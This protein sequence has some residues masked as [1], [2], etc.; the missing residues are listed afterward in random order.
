GSYEYKTLQSK[1]MESGKICNE[2]YTTHEKRDYYLN[3]LHSLNETQR[4][5]INPHFYKVDIS[6]D[7]YDLKNSLIDSLI[8]EIKEYYDSE[9]Q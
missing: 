8:K 4:R 1:V 9:Q 7:L 6:D 3:N 5:L 2:I